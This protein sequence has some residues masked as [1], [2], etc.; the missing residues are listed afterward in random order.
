[1]GVGLDSL[2]KADLVE[3]V[4]HTDS[5]RLAALSVR[6]GFKRRASRAGFKRLASN[7]GCKEVP[8]DVYKEITAETDKHNIGTQPLYSRRSW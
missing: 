1:M 6:A 7:K 2:E 8:E 5:R 4:V 3:T